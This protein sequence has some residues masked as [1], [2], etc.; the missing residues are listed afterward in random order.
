MQI[1]LLH[2]QMQMHWKKQQEEECQKR[3]MTEQGY[4]NMGD[5]DMPPMDGDDD[6]DMSA[7]EML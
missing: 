7:S 4:Q 1:M 5:Y 2:K 3:M 6:M